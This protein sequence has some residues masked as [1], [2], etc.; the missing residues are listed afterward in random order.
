MVV[1]P[2]GVEE[3]PC[4]AFPEPKEGPLKSLFLLLLLAAPPAF[5]QGGSEEGPRKLRNNEDIGTVPAVSL[6]DAVQAL[7]AGDPTPRAGSTWSIVTRKGSD[8]WTTSPLT[9]P[10]HRHISGGSED[11]ET[12]PIVIHSPSLEGYAAALIVGGG[13]TYVLM[14]TGAFLGGQGVTTL[15]ASTNPLAGSG[16]VLSISWWSEDEPF[17]SCRKITVKHERRVGQSMSSFLSEFQEMVEE[18]MGFYPPNGCPTESATAGGMKILGGHAALLARGNLPWASLLVPGDDVTSLPIVTGPPSNGD[19]MSISWQHD[20]DGS[21]PL[22]ATT[23]TASTER[24]SGEG[25]GQQARRLGQMAK[26]LMEIFPPNVS[27]PA[28][29]NTAGG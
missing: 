1:K 22:Q 18:S 3:A 8:D 29:G 10:S 28:G 27:T 9:A 2:R 6:E 20:P 7:L 25:S 24:R 12:L 4:T 16:D 19:V 14:S 15:P 26:A 21:G 11:G 13:P 5:A 17:Y 23:V